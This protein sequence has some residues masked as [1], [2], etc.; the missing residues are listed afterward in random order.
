[1]K[2]KLKP[3]KSKIMPCDKKHLAGKW[4]VTGPVTRTTVDATTF[5]PIGKS[6]DLGYGISAVEPKMFG[7]TRIYEHGLFESVAK[8]MVVK[9]NALIK[10]GR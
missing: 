5:K 4:E 8:A 1:M 9:H 3:V 10:G 2:K 6:L 7:G